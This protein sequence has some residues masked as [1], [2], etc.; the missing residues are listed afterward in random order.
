MAELSG[1]EV[2]ALL[3]EI[4]TALQGTY[5]N[6]IFSIGASQLVRLRKPGGED[7][8]LVASPRRGVW[9]SA[10]VS[11]R[12][13]TNQFTS[14]LRAELERAKFIGVAQVDLDRVFELDFEKEGRR[15]LIVELMPPGNVIVTDAE[16]KILAAQE[17]VRAQTRRVVHGGRYEPPKQSR[18]S[19][20]EVGLEDVSSMLRGEVTVGKAIGK[21]VALPRKYVAEVLARLGQAD[22]SPSASL[23]GR[24]EEV[25][26]VLGEMVEEARETPRP[27]LCETPRGD[28]IYVIPPRGVEVKE[29][30]KTVSEL[31]DRLYLQETEEGVPTPPEEG[32]RRELEITISKLKTESSSMLSGAAE[33]RL[34]ASAAAAGPREEALRILKESG[35]RPGREPT[36]PAAV[37]SAL[38]DRAKELEARSAEALDAA[39]RLEKKLSKIGPGVVSQ[40][41]PLPKRKLEWFEK[42]RWFPTSDGKLAV[43]GRDAQSN[44]LLLRRH[45]DDEDVVFHA[46]LFGSPFFILKGGRQQS[47]LEVLEV[48]QATVSFSSGW[49]TGLGAADAYWVFPDQVSKTTES[50]EYLAKGSF[51]VRGKKNFVRHAMLQLAVGLDQGGRVVAGPESAVAKSSPAYVVL[52]PHREKS[53]D[54]AKKVLRE[55]ANPGGQIPA[56]GLDDVVRALPSGGGKIVRRKAGQGFRDKP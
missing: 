28:E 48:A 51:V 6:N 3:K 21:H 54:T 25:V 13:E 10:R 56:P 16:G 34:A 33:A 36:S 30:A 46:D 38:F 53:S 15:R 7:V 32:R 27:C 47:D 55:L 22:E 35:V 50:G 11:E 9:V 23:G 19:P 31:C 5:V 41:K 40:R 18:L 1:F 4:G 24:E 2:L 12:G 39:G 17:E 45:L 37:A 8:W 42:F 49:K 26:R 14:K 20:V 44:T 52:V 43:G 29:T